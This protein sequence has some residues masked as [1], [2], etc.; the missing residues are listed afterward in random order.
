MY[1]FHLQYVCIFV[2]QPAEQ[3]SCWYFCFNV[4]FHLYLCFLSEHFACG[5]AVMSVCS[6]VTSP[7]FLLLCY[8]WVS[9]VSYPP[10]TSYVLN[11]ISI[12]RFL[13]NW[14]S[15]NLYSLL[16]TKYRKIRK[17]FTSLNVPTMLSTMDTRCQINE[18]SKEWSSNKDTSIGLFVSKQIHQNNKPMMEYN[19]CTYLVFHVLINILTSQNLSIMCPSGGGVQYVIHRHNIIWSN[20]YLGTTSFSRHGYK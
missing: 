20:W 12:A 18:A 2:L 19:T 6:S 15:V 8:Y 7:L 3:A 9:F 14:C 10:S 16:Q 17:V 1:R 5:G 4:K 13:Q 11:I